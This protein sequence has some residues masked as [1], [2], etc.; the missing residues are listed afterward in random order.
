MNQPCIVNKVS[1]Y[2]TKLH[3]DNLGNIFNIGTENLAFSSRS[4]SLV[5]SSSKI[6]KTLCNNT[7]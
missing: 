7:I 4:S 6:V 1:L 2:R 5:F 3:A